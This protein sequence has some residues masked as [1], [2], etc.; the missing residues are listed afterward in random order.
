MET[1]SKVRRWVKA[2]GMSIKEVCRRTGLSRNT[3]RKYLRDENA[4]PEYRMTKE[5]G[6]RRLLEHEVHLK[7]MY[8]ADLLR[9]VRERRSMQGL[10]EALV[11][12]GYTGSYDTVRRYIVRLK[13][14]STSVGQ[15]YIPLEFDAGD[16]LQFDWSHEV[17]VLGGIEQKIR[18]A[19]VRLCHSRKPFFVAYL[20]E[21]Q[22]MVLDAFNRAF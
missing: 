13:G 6:S 12:D 3:V 19:H 22:E 2:D 9:S 18:V 11:V 20:R 4:V 5:R 7:G 14:S 10:Y 17:V 1:V 15:G 21:S 8:E 16:A